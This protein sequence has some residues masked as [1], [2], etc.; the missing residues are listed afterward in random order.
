MN[1]GISDYPLNLDN[2]DD[3]DSEL[4]TM[5]WCYWRKNNDSFYGDENWLGKVFLNSRSKSYLNWNTVENAIKYLDDDKILLCYFNINNKWGNG[6][7]VNLVSYHRDTMRRTNGDEYNTV[8]FDVYDSNYPQTLLKLECIKVDMGSG[9]DAV[10]F[11]RYNTGNEFNEASIDSDNSYCSYFLN[12][13]YYLKG[14]EGNTAIFF[15]IYDDSGK[16][17]NVTD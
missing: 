12:D 6:H 15:G 8:V 5:L 2:L 1:K 17:L 9:G 11:Y 4:I 16:C 14:E 3:A 10:M 7:C 13:D